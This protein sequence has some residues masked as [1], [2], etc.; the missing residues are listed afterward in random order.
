MALY[1]AA[2]GQNALSRVD[3][4]LKT[5]KK[6]TETDRGV[7]DFMH[8]PVLNVAEKKA[9]VRTRPHT[10]IGAQPCLAVRKV[11]WRALTAAVCMFLALSLC[12]CVRGTCRS[13]RL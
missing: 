2:L 10:D 1:K 11:P 6:L 4:D 13:R 9:G 8:S 7:R 3:A 12:V 5:L